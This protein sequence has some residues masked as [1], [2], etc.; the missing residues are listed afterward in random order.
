MTIVRKLGGGLAELSGIH[1][2]LEVMDS[3]LDS[4][5]TAAAVNATR[6]I[7]RKG[8]RT[9]LTTTRLHSTATTRQRGSVRVL[10]VGETRLRTRFRR[11]SDSVA[12][13]AIINRK[14]V[15]GTFPGVRR[16]SCSRL[17]RRLGGELG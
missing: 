12:G 1:S 6:G 15:V 14:H 4:A 3:G 16:E 9:A 11:L 8:I 5:L 17:V 2:S 10:H 7:K 13:R